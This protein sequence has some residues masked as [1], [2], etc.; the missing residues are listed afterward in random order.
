MTHPMPQTA[1]CSGTP[2]HHHSL[3]RLLS[4]YLLSPCPVLAHAI[5]Q[6]LKAY[7]AN[8]LFDELS[9]VIDHAPS[10]RHGGLQ[11][12]VPDASSH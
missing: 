6:Q 5:A 7:A 4:L 8:P 1:A 12:P 11:A 2:D 10:S 3:T 9:A